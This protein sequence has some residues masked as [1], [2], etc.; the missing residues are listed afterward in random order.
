MTAPLNVLQRH[1]LKRQLADP[2]SCKYIIPTFVRLRPGIDP[3]RFAAAWNRAAASFEIFRARIAG[4]ASGGY[5]WRETDPAGPA[6]TVIDVADEDLLR[7]RDEIAPIDVFAERPVRA[8]LYRTPHRGVWSAVDFH[9]L[10]LDGF[11]FRALNGLVERAYFDP[12]AAIP[13]DGAF[14]RLAASAEE[15][16]SARFRQALEYWQDT[17]GRD[18]W[19]ACPR[20]DRDLGGA[21]QGEVFFELPVSVS[22]FWRICRERDALPVLLMQAVALRAIAEDTGVSR[23]L[24]GWTCHGR[25]RCDRDLG[26]PLIK[27]LVLGADT[28]LPD[29]E[30]LSVL[31]KRH[32]E[33][34][35]ASVCPWTATESCPLADQVVDLLYQGDLRSAEGQSAR[36]YQNDPDE[37]DGYSIGSQ[38]ILDIEIIEKNERLL[39]YFDYSAA[40]YSSERIQEFKA[41]FIRHFLAIT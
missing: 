22:E 24:I 1:M 25:T 7:L 34:L 31:R 32:Y 36:L 10:A 35:R 5:E 27:D 30:L 13:S 8:A 20:P 12:A 26:L 28:G 23:A 16:K 14:A 19:S 17:Y 9:H 41:L 18:T 39:V 4:S 38:N 6:M 11:G 21:A 2:A 15:E 37:N 29:E 40:R 3:V 33:A